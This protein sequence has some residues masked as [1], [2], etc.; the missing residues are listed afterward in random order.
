MENS[1]TV[2]VEAVA[3]IA[4]VSI[5]TVSRALNPRTAHL[6]AERT[7]ARVR[8]VAADLG[9]RPNVLAAALKGAETRVIGLL[10]SEFTSGHAPVLLRALQETLQERDYWPMLAGTSSWRESRQMALDA[11]ISRRVSGLVVLPASTDDPIIEQILREGIPAVV[12][13]GRSANRKVPSI[14]VDDRIGMSA[15]VGHLAKLGHR[16]IACV[17]G[18]R[19]VH[20]AESRSSAFR[21]VCRELRLGDSKDLV[22]EAGEFHIEAAADAVRELLAHREQP[23]AIV[24]VTDTLALGCMDELEQRGLRV[25]EDVSVTGFGDIPMMGRLGC[26]LTTVTV[27]AAEIGAQAG[28]YVLELI[29]GRRHPDMLLPPKLVIRQSSAPP[30][31]KSA[32]A[33]KRG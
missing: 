20:S 6:V 31:E 18:P 2:G 33:A 16:R 1:T 25:P 13:Y 26:P 29:A 30:R 32:I 4:K 12:A 19:R 8:K 11:L 21:A 28:R 23:T 17:T 15:L 24:A 10:S 14:T 7:R 9:Y 27:P 3:Q 22:V 5:A